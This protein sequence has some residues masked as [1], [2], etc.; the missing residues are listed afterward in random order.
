MVFNQNL[1]YK[2]RHPK[3]T[4]NTSLDHKFYIFYSTVLF[5]HNQFILVWIVFNLDFA[6]AKIE[7]KIAWDRDKWV[8]QFQTFKNNVKV[9]IFIVKPLDWEILWPCLS[10]D[11]LYIAEAQ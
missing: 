9:V 8:T 3:Q 4:E 10:F 11:M 6:K 5:S 1:T 2:Q 7:N